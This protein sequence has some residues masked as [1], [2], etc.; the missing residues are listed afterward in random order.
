MLLCQIYVH[1]YSFKGD[2]SFGCI[3][4]KCLLSSCSWICFCVCQLWPQLQ[5]VAG[6]LS[7]AC[8]W[9]RE[10]PL[11]VVTD[12]VWLPSSVQWNITTGR[13][14]GTGNLEMCSV[15]VWVW[16]SP[17]CDR[18]CSCYWITGWMWTRSTNKVEQLWWWQLLR[19]IWPQPDCCWI[20]VSTVCV[21]ED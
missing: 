12:G 4:L 13:Y 7:A 11:T 15:W 1:I 9:N 5:E 3:V 14:S 6:W 17:S 10:P 20:M 8:C 16:L 18:W 2:V 19:D 21:D